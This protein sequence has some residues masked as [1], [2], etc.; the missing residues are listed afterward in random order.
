MPIVGWRRVASATACDFC[1]MLASRGAVYSTEESASFE[2]H[3]PDELGRGGVCSC[4]VEPVY[5]RVPDPPAIVELRE[6]FQT[7]TDGLRGSAVQVAWRF[8]WRNR[9]N[10]EAL[11]QRFGAEIVAK[12]RG[13]PT[14]VP[15]VA[16]QIAG[17]R[18]A[19]RGPM[20][21]TSP[22]AQRGPMARTSPLAQPGP[23][24]RT[25]PLAEPG[26]PAKRSGPAR[27]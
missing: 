25:S 23:P 10:D 9:G 6:Q 5:A 22:L 3:A 19:Q 24:A 20:A 27:S 21:R 14:A 12:L 15:S 18:L 4:S 2:A 8:Y 16:E 11:L 26:P 17:P 7:V 1:V 13:R